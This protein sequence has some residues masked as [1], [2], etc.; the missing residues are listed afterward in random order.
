MHTTLLNYEAA[1]EKGKADSSYQQ[2]PIRKT[3]DIDMKAI[4]D[5]QYNQIPT[6]NNNNNNNNYGEIT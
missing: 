5:S 3:I 4:S 6:E 1:K 2:N